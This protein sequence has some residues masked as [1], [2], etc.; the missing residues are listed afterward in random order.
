MAGYT[1]VLDDAIA[2]WPLQETTGILAIDAA[3]PN[4]VTLKGGLDFQTGM[5]TGP[6]AWLPSA[7]SFD[8]ATHHVALPSAAALD[9]GVDHTLSL[10][11]RASS[12]VVA[13]QQAVI[14]FGGATHGTM[15][16]VDGG[17]LRL[18]TTRTGQYFDVGASPNALNEWHHVVGVHRDDRLELFVDGSLAQTA[19]IPVSWVRDG[20]NPGTLGA[21]DSA[22]WSGGTWQGPTAFFAADLAGVAAFDR[23]LQPDEV[24]ELFMG[25][26]PVN[27]ELP[28]I[29]G[30]ARVAGSLSLL[31]GVWDG[32][33]N[34]TVTTA[35]T[36]QLSGDGLGGW[37]DTEGSTVG[38]AFTL[39]TSFANKYVRVAASATN[40]GGVGEQ[41]YG[42]AHAVMPARWNGS[43][44]S[45]MASPS[46][47]AVAAT[48]AH[49]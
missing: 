5:A 15:I 33:G 2:S 47:L 27:V 26:E 21:A 36:M 31:P 43:V 23:A 4:D 10:W 34:G 49:R 39:P 24:L 38:G 29:D 12:S 18:T 37:V 32:L 41:A 8:G 45:L 46:G 13:G 16:Y 22:T 14:E 30:E 3:G 48:V 25:P 28:D 9:L 20:D 42:P 1:S 6:R 19:N 44:E 35:T 7:L 40:D 11:L 17:Y